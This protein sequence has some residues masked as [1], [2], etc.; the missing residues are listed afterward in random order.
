MKPRASAAPMV[1][2]VDEDTSLLRDLRRLLGGAGFT[3][4]TFGSLDD[5]LEAEH[6]ADIGCLVLNVYLNGMSGFDV[7]DVLVSWG[8]EIPVKFVGAGGDARMNERARKA[9]AV[10][11]FPKPVDGGSLIGALTEAIDHDRG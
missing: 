1:C 5:F 10:A 11:F 3:V 8:S 7:Q 9:G 2:V 6:P 4:E